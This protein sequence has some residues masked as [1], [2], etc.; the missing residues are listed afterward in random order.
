MKSLILDLPRLDCLDGTAPYVVLHGADHLIIVSTPNLQRIPPEQFMATLPEGTIA[1]GGQRH[2]A[3]RMACLVVRGPALILTP[4]WP[5]IGDVEF[6]ARR[7]TAHAGAAIG[8]E[9]W[10]GWVACQ[11]ASG[12]GWMTS[13]QYTNVHRLDFGKAGEA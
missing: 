4:S 8:W 3:G 9:T 10:Q 1:I 2:E 11:E 13:I 5:W 12:L 6:L 7:A